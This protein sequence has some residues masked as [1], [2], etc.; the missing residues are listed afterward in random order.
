LSQNQKRKSAESSRNEILDSLGRQAHPENQPMAEEMAPN[1]E[2]ANSTLL[3]GQ[4][5]MPDVL[6]GAKATRHAGRFAVIIF[7]A[8]FL[9]TWGY[10][11]LT[12]AYSIPYVD[13]LLQNQAVQVGIQTATA[14]PLPAGVITASL[15]L[16]AL[17]AL[18]R[19]KSSS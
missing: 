19:R 1:M 15:V 5:A 9:A 17:Y 18:H 8:G 12:R 2:G 7:I 11:Y 6:G 3:D 13:T 10:G 16:A 14:N 4:T